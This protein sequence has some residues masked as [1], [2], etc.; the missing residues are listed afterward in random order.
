MQERLQQKEV[1]IN[2]LNN[3]I[4]ELRVKLEVAGFTIFE[5][6]SAKIHKES[7]DL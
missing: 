7:L 6:V 3:T 4:R 1:I 5:R 2:S